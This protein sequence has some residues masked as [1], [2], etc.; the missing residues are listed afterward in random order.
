MDLEFRVCREFAGLEQ[1][2]H[3]CLWCDGFNPADYTLDGPSPQITGTCWI[4]RSPDESEWEFALFLPNSVRSRE[5]I[6]WARLLPPENV[7]RWLAFD[8][9][10]QYIEIDPAAA[11]PDLE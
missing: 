2:R 4:G 1:R 5:E 7:T 9:Q 8:E 10:R 6:D 3:R 11:V